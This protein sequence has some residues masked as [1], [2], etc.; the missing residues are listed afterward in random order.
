MEKQII[1]GNYFNKRSTGN[2]IYK[3]LMN[4]FDKHFVKFLTEV[5]PLKIL[6]FGC[7]EGEMITIVKQVFPDAHYTAVDIEE[8]LLE[9]AK[10]KG[11]DKVLLLNPENVK[12]PFADNSFDLVIAAEVLEHVPS[13]HESLKEIKRVTSSHIIASVPYEPYWCM[14]NMARLK[15]LNR[16]GNTPGHVNHWNKKEFHG[17]ISSEFCI[18]DSS[19][20]FPWLMVLAKKN[21]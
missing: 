20:P 3:K 21:S 6:E 4:N 12:L 7:G 19:V 8:N 9:S 17:M 2:S 14:L 13:P 18:M 5:K 1:A 16:F 11:A 15:Y 10:Q